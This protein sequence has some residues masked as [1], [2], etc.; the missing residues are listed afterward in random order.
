MSYLHGTKDKKLYCRKQSTWYIAQGEKKEKER[1]EAEESIS[2]QQSKTTLEQTSKGK[3]AKPPGQR[4]QKEGEGGGEGRGGLGPGC[5][6]LGVTSIIQILGSWRSSMRHFSMKRFAPFD[7]FCPTPS[8]SI[9]RSTRMP[10]TLRSSLKH[11]Q[12]HHDFSDSP[13]DLSIDRSFLP[14]GK[15]GLGQSVLSRTFCVI[16]L[17]ISVIWAQTN[18]PG[19]REQFHKCRL[20]AK[21]APVSLLH[22]ALPRWRSS[23]VAL[24]HTT[25]TPVCTAVQYF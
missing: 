18:L 10:S 5:T 15:Q 12:Q 2:T 23:C 25:I 11:H 6:R 9:H 19:C 21:G 13:P 1:S 7:T 4:G 24:R 8:R 17:Q 14:K 3:F 20:F 16:C 22:G